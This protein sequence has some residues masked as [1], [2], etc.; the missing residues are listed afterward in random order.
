MDIQAADDVASREAPARALTLH[1]RSRGGP[2]R[3][4]RGHGWGGV[5]ICTVRSQITPIRANT[6]A[7]SIRHLLQRVC[8]MPPLMGA[9]LLAPP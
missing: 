6:R 7:T 9:G 3:R 5:A 1:G 8:F 4:K 2:S